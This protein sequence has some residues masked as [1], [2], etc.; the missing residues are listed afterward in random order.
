MIALIIKWSSNETEEK[1]KAQFYVV[2][3]TVVNFMYG[4]LTLGK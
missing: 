1:E 2:L 3:M 4:V